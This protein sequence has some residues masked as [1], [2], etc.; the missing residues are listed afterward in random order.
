M[1]KKHHDAYDICIPDRRNSG[2][3]DGPFTQIFK[4]VLPRT[5][6]SPTATKPKA[7]V[8][9]RVTDCLVHFSH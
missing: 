8:S 2:I 9:A 6:S 1:R 7:E 5:S 4:T 3:G